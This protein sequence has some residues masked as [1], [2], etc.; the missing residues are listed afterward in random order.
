MKRTF[1]RNQARNLARLAPALLIALALAPPLR[2]QAP[3]LS[4][5]TSGWETAF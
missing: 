3:T 5:D 4:K 1:A 2:A